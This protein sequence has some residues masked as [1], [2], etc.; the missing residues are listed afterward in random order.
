METTVKGLFRTTEKY[1]GKEITLF[2]WVRNNRAQKEF[3]FINFHDGT[4]FDSVQV[5]YEDSKLKNFKDVQKIRVG[6]SIL[7]KGELILTPDAKQ[8]IE[9]KATYIELLGDSPEDYPI[10]PKRH[11]RE[12]LREVAHLRMRTNLFHAVFRLRSVAA[13][14][15]HEFFQS[16]GFIYTHTPIITGNDGEGAGQMFNVTTLPLDKV[17]MNEDQQVDYKKDFFGKR[18][19]LTVT[20]QLEAEA[21]ALAF[22]NVYTFGPTFRAEN[23]N[24]T[25]HASEFWMIEPEMAFADLNKNMDVAEDMVKFIIKYVFEKLPEEMVFFDKF[26]EPGLTDRLLK[27]LTQPFVKITHKEAIDIL[28]KSNTKFENLPKHGQDINT[29]HEKYLTEKHFDCPVFITDWPKG[30]KAFYMRMNDDNETVAAM[31]L[32][33]P[34]SGELIGGSQ[35]EERYDMLMK[36]MEEM[37]IP[38]ED[39]KWYTDLRR[40]GGCVHAGYGLGFERLI[41]YLSGVENIRDVIPFPRTPKNCEF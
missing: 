36:R 40:Y 31:D 15:V 7:V 25:R 30:I 14:A 33:V 24:T 4:F 2:G 28:I 6:S 39:L 26:V 9:V 20:G 22:K 34:G 16:Q 29:E 11:S 38:K 1:I 27:V 37:D 12:F 3:G 8:P 21:F 19:N 32:L 13:F 23:S 5:V 35:R 17:P 10:Q 18:T 41:M